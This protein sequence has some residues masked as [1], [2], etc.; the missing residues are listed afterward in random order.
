MIDTTK[1][2]AYNEVRFKF[3]NTIPNAV[4]AGLVPA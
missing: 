3:S 4:G 2:W 1:N